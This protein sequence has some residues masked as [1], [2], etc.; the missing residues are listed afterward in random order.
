MLRS[1]SCLL[2]GLFL[3]GKMKHAVFMGTYQSNI[4]TTAYLNVNQKGTFFLQLY[5]KAKCPLVQG[6]HRVSVIHSLHYSK[7]NS[8]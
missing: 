6:Q 7:Y 2:L 3:L 8:I 1:G 5:S 4:Q